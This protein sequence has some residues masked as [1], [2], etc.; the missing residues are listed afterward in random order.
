[1]NIEFHRTFL[2]ILKVT[3]LFIVTFVCAMMI[4]LIVSIG[5]SRDAFLRA[6]NFFGGDSAVE[7][8][9]LL[10]PRDES[11]DSD[12]DEYQIIQDDYHSIVYWVNNCRVVVPIEEI[13]PN[14]IYSVEYGREINLSERSL[15]AL[16]NSLTRQRSYLDRKMKSSYNFLEIA[17]IVTISIGLITTILVSISSTEFGRGDGTQQRTIRILAIV[18]PA[19]GTAVAAVIAFYSPQAQWTQASRTLASITQL[20]SQMALGVWKLP[21]LKPDPDPNKAVVITQL[22]EWA[23]RYSDI[24]TVSSATGG[25]SAASGVEQGGPKSPE[26]PT[27]PPPLPGH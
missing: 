26:P 23:K 25:S 15:M 6:A 4:A 10:F 17:T 27:P 3:V 20:H 8:F 1:M 2:A 5:S 14:K 12:N 11:S 19:L 16:N 13:E 24:Q 7:E 21:C 9:V 18:F 22:D